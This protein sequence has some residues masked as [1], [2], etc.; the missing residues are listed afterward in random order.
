MNAIAANFTNFELRL[1]QCCYSNEFDV[2]PAALSDYSRLIVGSGELFY[3]ENRSNRSERCGSKKIQSRT[4]FPQVCAKDRGRTDYQITNKIVRADHLPTFLRF[5]IADDQRF[6]RCL[7]KLFK[8]AN[9][10]RD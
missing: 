4:E 5:R 3:I 8:A 1:I 2:S 7:S 6:A 9:H 10:K